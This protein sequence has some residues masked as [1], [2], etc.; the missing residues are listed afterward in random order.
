MPTATYVDYVLDAINREAQSRGLTLDPG[1]LELLMAPGEAYLE[2]HPEF[3]INDRRLEEQI[4][5]LFDA[6]ERA[7]GLEKLTEV[8]RAHVSVVLP[9]LACH[10]LWFC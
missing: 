10:Y 3:E 2:Q 1:A 8:S 6:L 5:T 9:T 7:A 4:S